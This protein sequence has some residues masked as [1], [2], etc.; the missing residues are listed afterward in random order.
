MAEVYLHNWLYSVVPVGT[1]ETDSVW[2]NNGTDY[3]NVVNYPLGAYL[4]GYCRNCGKAF[5]ELIPSNPYSYTETQ[6]HV[7]KF[8][9]VG[10]EEGRGQ[11][12]N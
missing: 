4:T 12:G 7:N 10:P 8:G 5:S 9:C 11:V 3:E 6:M 2:K 1:K